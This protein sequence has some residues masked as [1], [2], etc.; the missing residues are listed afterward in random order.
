MNFKD[1]S[2]IT[3]KNGEQSII[4]GIHQENPYGTVISDKLKK[5]Y[6]TN[7]VFNNCTGTQT[8]NTY[9]IDFPMTKKELEA[10]KNMLED[11]AKIGTFSKPKVAVPITYTRMQELASKCNAVLWIKLFKQQNRVVLDFSLLNSDE[12]SKLLDFQN[13]TKEQQMALLN[14]MIIRELRDIEKVLMQQRG[15]ELVDKDA[16]A[17]H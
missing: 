9:C 16:Q 2:V 5:E 12:K 13:W 11:R 6:E 8:F 15:I 7:P 10:Y 4:W 14:E 17:T 1:E 3:S